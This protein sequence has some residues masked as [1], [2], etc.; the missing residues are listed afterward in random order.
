MTNTYTAPNGI[1]LSITPV[2]PQYESPHNANGSDATTRVSLISYTPV[3]SDRH[4]PIHE[5]AIVREVL[6]EVLV[7]DKPETDL[8][9][10]T[11][12]R[13]DLS[14]RAI[15][16]ALSVL[17][18]LIKTVETAKEETTVEQAD[19]QPIPQELKES[20]DKIS[21]EIIRD[22]LKRAC[23]LLIRVDLDKRKEFATS[24]DEIIKSN[25]KQS[26]STE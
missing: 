1:Y 6:S 12:V 21:D 22:A 23:L 4:R 7:A 10:F 14:K 25:Q 11:Q 26:S 24:L 19:E 17:S 16:N 15:I 18:E 2:P 3:G 20:L 5:Q 9:D 8:R 13:L